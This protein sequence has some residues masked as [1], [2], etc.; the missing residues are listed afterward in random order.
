GRFTSG[1]SLRISAELHYAAMATLTS[2]PWST[3]EEE[4]EDAADPLGVVVVLKP[5]QTTG[6]G[7]GW[8]AVAMTKAEVKRPAGGA[9]PSRAKGRVT[10][11]LDNS[12]LWKK[13]CGC[14]TEML[15]TR[16]GRLMFPYCSYRLEG[17][18]PDRMYLLAIDF[19]PADNH[20]YRWTKGGWQVSGKGDPHMFG[21]AVVHPESPATGGHWMGGPVT[22]SKLKLTN[23]LQ[24]REGHV[25]LRSMHCYLPH[26]YVVPVVGED[27]IRLD[28]PGVDVFTFPQTEFFAVTSYQNHK[29]TMLKLCNNP[30]AK[31]FRE[32]GHLAKPNPKRPPARAGGGRDG[33]PEDEKAITAERGQAP[34]TSDQRSTPGQ[35]G[36]EKVLHKQPA[37]AASAGQEEETDGLLHVD[38]SVS[39]SSNEG[40]GAAVSAAR[41]KTPLQKSKQA[42]HQKKAAAIAMP[43]ISVVPKVLASSHKK[44]TP[45]G[46]RRGKKPKQKC[47]S[48]WRSTKGP[49]TPNDMSARPLDVEMQPALDDVEG[50]LFVS[51][52]SKV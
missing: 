37:Q 45:K 24:D 30:N 33:P 14:R 43:K 51:F 36:G 26:L 19:R 28:G 50:L 46:S 47:W 16:P 41:Q 32:N 10:V 27:A 39:G 21:R 4:E 29:I 31:C 48:H 40:R 35:D 49:A 6:G 22:F 3:D 8:A 2:L 7:R 20:R 42:K 11:A 18:D 5:K 23:N 9:P 38:D 34:R 12:A 44:F 13:F 52:T 25:V 15:L 1:G 17:L